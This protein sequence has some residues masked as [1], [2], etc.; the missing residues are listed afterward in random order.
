M[1]PQNPVRGSDSEAAARTTSILNIIAGLYL[2][3]SPWFYGMASNVA[4]TWNSVVFG[5]VVIILAIVH[6]SVIRQTWASWINALIGIWV[7]ISPWV[8]TFSVNSAM[9]WSCVVCGIVILV[10]GAWSASTSPTVAT[11]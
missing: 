10:L 1:N 4:G 6:L 3:L 5:V 7:I 2:L 8:Y 9:T 11:R